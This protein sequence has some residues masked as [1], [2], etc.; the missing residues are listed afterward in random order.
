VDE[1]TCLSLIVIVPKKNG[2]LK[3][4]V[5]FKK[6]N[7]ATKKDFFPLPFTDEIRNTMVGCETYSFMDGYYGYH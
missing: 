3:I 7:V 1:A 4:C 6:L 5:D 2:K